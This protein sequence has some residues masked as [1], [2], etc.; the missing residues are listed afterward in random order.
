MADD[1]TDGKVVDIWDLQ[2]ANYERQM[3]AIMDAGER[4]AFIDRLQERAANHTRVARRGRRSGDPRAEEQ[5]RLGDELS[6]IA[7]IL[8][9]TELEACPIREARQ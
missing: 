9:D 7:H 3:A 2:M 1:E 5:A 8:L 4:F 6:W